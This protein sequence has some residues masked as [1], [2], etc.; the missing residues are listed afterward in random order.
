MPDRLDHSDS[1]YRVLR[2]QE[3]IDQLFQRRRVESRNAL[4]QGQAQCGI[5]IAEGTEQGFHRAGVSQSTQCPG[6]R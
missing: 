3:E 2:F 1:A 5:G 4:N 6:N